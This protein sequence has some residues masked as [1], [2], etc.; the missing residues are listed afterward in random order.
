M[1][2]ALALLS[3]FEASTAEGFPLG[4]PGAEVLDQLERVTKL[5]EEAKAYYKAQLA[6]DPH[7]V[8][9]W[10]LRPGAMR[11]SL[12]N[13]QRVWEKLQDTLSTEQFL[14]AVKIEVGKLQDLWAQKSG[15]PSTRAK[16]LF[17]KELGD[18]IIELQSAPSL[19]RTKL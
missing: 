16:E 15:I 12:A 19:V 13:P 18:L 11:R 14:C 8:P 4:Q 10:A 17:N 9:G 1:N 5:L 7:C 2:S 6:E 3:K